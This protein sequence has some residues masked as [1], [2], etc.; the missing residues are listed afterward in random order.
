MHSLSRYAAVALVLTVG[1]GSTAFGS[2]FS[3]LSGRSGGPANGGATCRTCHGNAVGGGI[4]E[5]LGVPSQ[6]DLNA[7][8]DLTVRV[9]DAARVG[10][11]FQ[12]SVEDAAGNHVG[13][14]S[15]IDP[16]FTALNSDDPT[17]VNHTPE[18]VD[19]SV[20]N[21]AANGNSVSYAVRW[22]APSVDEGPVTF[23]AAGN[24]IN[25]NF[26]AS[27]DLIYTTSHTASATAG[28]PAV[29]T[30][31]L[32][33]LTLMGLTAATLMERRKPAAVTA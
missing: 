6:Y 29:S 12:V 11:G 26:S 32:V 28:V 22:T 16:V 20:A 1:S 19:D 24:A 31:G 15:L 27:G 9:S 13:I 8:Y 7:V 4:V 33:V 30:W 10:A 17:Y 18:G 14:L 5:I 23:W 2:R 25:N 21:W 3:P